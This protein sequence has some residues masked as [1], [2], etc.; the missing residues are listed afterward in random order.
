MEQ[1]YRYPYKPL[2]ELIHQQYQDDQIVDAQGKPIHSIPQEIVEEDE[3]EFNLES[4]VTLARKNIFKSKQIAIIEK[5]QERLEDKANAYSLDSEDTLSLTQAIAVAINV[6][7]S[8]D[9]I[10]DDY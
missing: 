7:E 4:N 1:P 3:P 5:L 10:Y 8:V 6:L 9:N 2:V